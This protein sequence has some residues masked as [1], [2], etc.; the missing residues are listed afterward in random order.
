VG[1]LGLSRAALEHDMGYQSSVSMA[2]FDLTTSGA[3]VSHQVHA[4]RNQFERQQHIRDGS[5][6]LTW[7]IHGG[8]SEYY[9]SE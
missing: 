2:S 3:L 9:G 5:G 6:P 1:E 8:I 7:R 4:G